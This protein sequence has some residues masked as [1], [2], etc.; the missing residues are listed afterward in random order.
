MKLRYYLFNYNPK[1]C[2]KDNI[3]LRDTF[4]NEFS[5]IINT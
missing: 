3:V 2:K 4:I 1:W 5:K